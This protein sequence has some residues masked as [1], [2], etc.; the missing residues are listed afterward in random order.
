MPLGQSQYPENQRAIPLLTVLLFQ[1][2]S[3]FSVVAKNDI[4]DKNEMKQN[5]PIKIWENS[6]S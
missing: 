6:I 5:V 4:N 2:L 1:N 3:R